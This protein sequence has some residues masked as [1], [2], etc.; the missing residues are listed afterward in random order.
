M[1][2]LFL[3]V[4]V[5]VLTSFTAEEQVYICMSKNAKRYH[6]AQDCRGLSNCK[7]DIEKVA[8]SEAKKQGKTL[9]GYED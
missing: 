8:L 1:K 5:T 6:L 4:A 7:A 2:K 3:V 9:C